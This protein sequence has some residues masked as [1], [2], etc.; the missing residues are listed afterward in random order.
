[1]AQVPLEELLARCP[2]IYKLVVVAARRAKQLAEGAPKLVEG[3]FKKITSI[4]LEEIRQGKVTYTPAEDE[5]TTAGKGK[6][7]KG[8]AGAKKKKA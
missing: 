2:S 4:A 6:R 5:A 8:H 3:D 7:G 1:M